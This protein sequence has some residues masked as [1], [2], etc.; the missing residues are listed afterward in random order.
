MSFQ[1]NYIVFVC[2]VWRNKDW[3]QGRMDFMD[4]IGNDV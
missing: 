4:K 3:N 2:Q 1:T